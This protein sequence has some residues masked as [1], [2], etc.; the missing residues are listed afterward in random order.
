MPG[1]RAPPAPVVDE[2]VARLLEHPLLVADDDLGGPE[3]LEPLEA[4]VAVDDAPVQV[5]EVGGG[6]P[7][8]VELDHRPQV[9]RDHRQ[10]GE[11]HPLRTRAG[12]AERLDEAQP[13]DRLLPALPRRLPDL[14]V[15][16]PRELLEVHPDD[17]VADRLGAHPG[18]EDATAARPS[19]EPSVEVPHLALEERLHRLQALELVADAS[20]LVLLAFG[21]VGVLLALGRERLVHGRLEV[22]DLLGGGA[23]LALLALGD[24][25]VDPHRLVLDDLAE[26][27]RGGPAALLAGRDDDLAGRLE[28]DRGLRHARP[29]L[30]ELGL[31]GLR[32]LGDLG[33]AIRPE[34]LELRL[35]GRQGGVQLVRMARDVRAQL[36]RE[37]L[38]LLTDATAAAL[39]LLV[40]RGERPT[41]GVLV[42]VRDDVEREVEDALEI[43]G[44][45]VQEDPEAA[46]RPLEVPD[47]AHGARELDVSHPLAPDLR[48]GHLDAALVADDPLVPDPLVL[49]A[50]AF[51][52]LGGTEDAL[53]EE[54]VLLR[55]ERA[56]V[57][58]LRLGHLSLGPLPDLVRAG[59]RDADRAEVVDLDHRSPWRRR[60]RPAGRWSRT[61]SGGPPSPSSQWKL[62]Q[63]SKPAR[64]MPPRSGSG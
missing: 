8:A 63:S 40:D 27:V 20:Q 50:V 7:A 59:E 58:R 24:L 21:L 47:V 14:D 62:D 3:L 32:L 35:R 34:L 5:V 36:V 42:D 6:E 61:V 55:L 33:D 53:V 60:A 45:D 46:G 11:D 25:G 9:R 44:A 64:L 51:P 48:A 17:D 18:E 56:V 31:D 43:P 23:R 57:D 16:S 29:E 1:D 30:G 22:A 38:Q 19:P 28:R 49:A 13:L 12:A 41:P 4:I 15:E 2:G 52:V 10:D 37:L 39:H 26:L 54:A